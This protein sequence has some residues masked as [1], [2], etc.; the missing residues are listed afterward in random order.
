MS[1]H[2]CVFF[3]AGVVCV[4]GDGNV[5]GG[6]GALTCVCGGCMGGGGGGSKVAFLYKYK[7]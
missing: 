1:F 5:L 4:W 6:R 7:V 3:C 2:N